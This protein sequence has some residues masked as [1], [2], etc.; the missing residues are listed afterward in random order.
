[1][2]ACNIKVTL[3]F[4][5]FTHTGTKIS[6][7]RQKPLVGHS[8]DQR[9]NDEREVLKR[10]ESLGKPSNSGWPALS[11]VAFGYKNATKLWASL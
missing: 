2:E 1:M 8:N 4:F 7:P 6:G 5:H 10:H 3:F 9:S 11:S